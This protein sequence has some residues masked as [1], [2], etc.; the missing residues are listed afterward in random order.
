MSPRKPWGRLHL[1]PRRPKEHSPPQTLVGGR[2]DRAELQKLQH[3]GTEPCVLCVQISA[4]STRGC[5]KSACRVCLRWPPL[6]VQLVCFFFHGF[7]FL[8]VA[9]KRERE[10]TSRALWGSLPF[11]GG[12]A[13]RRER[14]SESHADSS[15]DIKGAPSARRFR[16]FCPVL[17]AR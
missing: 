12:Y 7:R 14:E 6:F 17:H 15:C 4:Q 5:R 2:L 8:E 10:W 9:G 1:G 3:L 11:G 13:C 16:D